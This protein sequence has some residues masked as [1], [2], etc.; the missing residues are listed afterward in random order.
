[1]EIALC[2]LL[3][4]RLLLSLLSEVE[5]FV[6]F[7]AV[8]TLSHS[9]VSDRTERKEVRSF[10]RVPIQNLP[11]LFLLEVSLQVLDECLELLLDIAVQKSQDVS[12]NTI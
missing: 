10:L 12:E 6:W 4:Y 7:V 3:V 9:K 2:S 1:M 8:D 5:T 11:D